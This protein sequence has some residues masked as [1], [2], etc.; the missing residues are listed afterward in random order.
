MPNSLDHQRLGLVFI[1]LPLSSPYFLGGGVPCVLCGSPSYCPCHSGP[2]RCWCPPPCLGV[3]YLLWSPCGKNWTVSDLECT[4][5]SWFSVM[6]L[7]S[8]MRWHVAPSS[9]WE[10][11]ASP[12]KGRRSEGPGSQEDLRGPWTRACEPKLS[13]EWPQDAPAQGSVQPRVWR[14]NTLQ[15]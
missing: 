11:R 13:G 15:P 9:C 1:L 10:S 12:Q 8:S 4:L 5:V 14:V 3:V 7:G 6:T 2:L